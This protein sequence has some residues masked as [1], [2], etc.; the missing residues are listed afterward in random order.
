MG[1]IESCELLIQKIFEIL[2][3]IRKYITSNNSIFVYTWIILWF[4]SIWIYHIQF[5]LM[6]LFC[7]FL[8]FI[9][10]Y[11][12]KNNNDGLLPVIF[13][14]NNKERSLKVIKVLTEDLLWE[15]SEICSGE[16]ILPSGV[17]KKGDVIINCKGNVSI[18]H[19]PSNVIFGAFNFEE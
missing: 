12:K 18:R 17:I 5:F 13:S 14:P 11:D 9:D 10:F 3:I 1:L 7:L 4:V 19:V 8:S 15:E 2:I 16:G 6:G